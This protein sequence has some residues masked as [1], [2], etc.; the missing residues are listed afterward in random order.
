MIN[1]ECF[2]C[3]QQLVKGYLCDQCATESL[4]MLNDKYRVNFKPEWNDHC[5]ICGEYKNRTILNFP[6]CGPICDKCIMESFNSY[7]GS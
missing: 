1:L 2:I 6:S 4:K 7:D 5:L 3:S